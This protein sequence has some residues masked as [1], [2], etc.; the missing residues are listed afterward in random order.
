MILV[1]FFLPGSNVSKK[2]EEGVFDNARVRTELARNYILVK[3][4]MAENTALAAG[5]GVY[6]GCAVVAYTH[7][8]TALGQII[9]VFKPEEFLARLAAFSAKR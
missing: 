9:D 5:L 7:D 1:Y 6:R 4:N 8:G 3:L 2:L